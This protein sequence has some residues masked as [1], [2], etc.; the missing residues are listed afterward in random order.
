MVFDAT[1]NGQAVE[2]AL[3]KYQ[4][5]RRIFQVEKPSSPHN[6]KSFSPTK[7]AQALSSKNYVIYS[8]QG[9]VGGEA[10]ADQGWQSQRGGE[11]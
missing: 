4:A 5:E 1:D 6:T 7:R 3:R 10:G 8:D 11:L 9:A 2:R